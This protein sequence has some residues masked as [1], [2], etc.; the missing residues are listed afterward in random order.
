MKFVLT[1]LL[2]SIIF[3]FLFISQVFARENEVVLNGAGLKGT[4][5]MPKTFKNRPRH[6]VVAGPYLY[7]YEKERRN[8][9]GN[10]MI[11]SRLA[12]SNEKWV[13][14]NDWKIFRDLTESR[15]QVW[16]PTSEEPRIGSHGK[17][18]VPPYGPQEAWQKIKDD[19]KFEVRMVLSRISRA[20]LFNSAPKVWVVIVRHKIKKLY[21]GLWTLNSRYNRAAAIELTEKIA[22]SYHSSATF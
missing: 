12:I 10:L 11:D 22:E 14:G 9:G 19:A 7:F 5:W 17:F 3:A 16:Q 1:V 15:T 2:I 21:V 18:I 6:A 4:I 20:G 13:K 8:L